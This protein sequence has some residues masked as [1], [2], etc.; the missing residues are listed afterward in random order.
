MIES[1]RIET[2]LSANY[3]KTGVVEDFDVSF[4]HGDI[5]F[6]MLE[7]TPEEI[8]RLTRDIREQMELLLEASREVSTSQ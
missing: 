6:Q 1:P 5:S 4:N 7:M 2:Y 8:R 3:S